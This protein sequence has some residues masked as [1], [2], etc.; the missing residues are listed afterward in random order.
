MNPRQTRNSS[1]L[2]WVRG[3]IWVRCCLLMGCSAHFGP[4]HATWLTYQLLGRMIDA[5]TTWRP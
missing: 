5:S 3:L 2:I 4:H 1:A